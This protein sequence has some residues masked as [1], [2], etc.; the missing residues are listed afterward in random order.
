M[1]GRQGLKH[2]RPSNERYLAMTKI[3]NISRLGAIL[4]PGI[5][6]LTPTFAIAQ[7]QPGASPG[8]APPATSQTA[9]PTGG[10]TGQPMKM[11][12]DKMKSGMGMGDD[13]MKSGMGM[14]ED[15]MK[16]GMGMKDCNGKPCGPP[17]GAAGQMG[18]MTQSPGMAGP[19]SSNSAPAGQA[20]VK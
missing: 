20:P 8:A 15:K 4:L 18:G 19:G 17:K 3:L 12:D 1:L 14:G 6:A 13:K 9:P 7:A 5:L 16:S 2:Q 11:G 10:T